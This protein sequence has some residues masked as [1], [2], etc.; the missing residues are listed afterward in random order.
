MKFKLK[1]QKFQELLEKLIVKDIFPSCVFAVKEGKLFSNQKEEHGRALRYV[2]F[3][4]TYF[5]EIDDSNESIEIDIDRTLNVVKNIPSNTSLV[6]ETVGNKLSI[7]RLILDKDGKEIGQKGF[8]RISYKEPD[9]EVK[10]GMPFE[11]KDKKI[12][13]V[14]DAKL[15]LE[16]VLN[17]DLADFKSLSNFA[18]SLK[19]EFY[20]FNIKEDKLSVRVGDLHDFSDYDT[21]YPECEIK[22]GKSLEVTLSYGLSSVADTFREKHV[23]IKTNNNAPAWISEKGEGYIIGVLIPPYVE[24]E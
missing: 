22:K 15:P 19:T 9:G 3:Q 16:I 8:T 6:V 11:M 4:K 18:S 12:P 13:L 7:S 1:Q 24:S 14:G 23:N 20:K 21:E 10:D 5:E 2:S 17:I